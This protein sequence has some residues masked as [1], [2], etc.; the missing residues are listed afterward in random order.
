MNL[1]RKIK[2]NSEMQRI[3]IICTDNEFYR[4]GEKYI[5]FDNEKVAYD[6]TLGKDLKWIGMYLT[7]YRI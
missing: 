3:F 4:E 5:F 6:Y 1:L 2:E 7:R